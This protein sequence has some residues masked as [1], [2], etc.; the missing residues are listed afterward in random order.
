[1]H[2]TPNPLGGTAREPTDRLRPGRSDA[3]RADPRPAGRRAV[4]D[5]QRLAGNQATVALLT[6]ARSGAAVGAGQSVAGGAGPVVQRARVPSGSELALLLPAGGA[7]LPAHLRGLRQ[8]VENV[9]T[10]TDSTLGLT[11]AERT[12]VLTTAKGGLSDTA[13]AALPEQDRLTRLAAA[14]QAVRPDRVVADPGLMGSGARSHTADAHNIATLV[15]N[16]GQLI[17]D[18]LAAPDIDLWLKQIFGAGNGGFA[19]RRY[20]LA[21]VFLNRLAAANKILSDRSGYSAESDLGGTTVAGHHIELTPDVIDNPGDVNNQIL[22]LH[23]AMHAGNELVEDFRYIGEAGFTALPG[24]QKL[25]NAAHYEVAAFRLKMPT[26]ANAFPDPAA[27]GT[28]LTFTPGT[29][30][31]PAATLTVPEDARNQASGLVEH[32][33]SATLDLYDEWAKIYRKPALWPGKR[34]VMAFWSVVENLTV[35]EKTSVTVTAVRGSDTAAVSQVDLALSEVLSHRIGLVQR[36]L[37]IADPVAFENAHASA[38]EVA[39]ATDLATHRALLVLCAVRASGLSLTGTDSR[40]A[41]VITRLGEAKEQDRVFVAR[42]PV[43]P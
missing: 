23:E 14:I 40:D 8:V 41:A 32:A 37:R 36:T 22:T 5:L 11:P 34:T 29:S 4:V 1:M 21:K 39:G 31:G 30:S 2:R 38:S 17:D 15:T 28:F 12:T 27:P 35:H 16:V 20:Q 24:S 13:F 9:L 42:P 18:V 3:R 25:R 7:N 19:K 10:E 6:G 26:H 43:F 33:W